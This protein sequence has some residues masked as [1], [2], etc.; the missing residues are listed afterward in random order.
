[1]NLHASD[2]RGILFSRSRFGRPLGLTTVR[3]KVQDSVLVRERGSM[4]LYIRRKISRLTSREEGGDA[5]C[6]SNRLG[7]YYFD[8]FL[9]SAERYYTAFAL[10]LASE[11]GRAHV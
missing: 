7:R 11:I 2:A 5:S 10:V 4:D 8:L 6:G 1:M 9:N 3:S